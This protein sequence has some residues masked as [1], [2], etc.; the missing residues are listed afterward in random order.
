MQMQVCFQH[1][2]NITCLATLLYGML[3]FR[4]V[5]MALWSGGLPVCHPPIPELST[6]HKCSIFL[7][8]INFANTPSAIG[9]LHIF[10]KRM[11]AFVNFGLNVLKHTYLDTRIELF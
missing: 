4:K 9:D 7:S 1:L 2:Q 5:L 3:C 8:F 6:A 11:N 10:P